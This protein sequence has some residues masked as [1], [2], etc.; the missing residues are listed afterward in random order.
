MFLRS[1]NSGGILKVP[2]GFPQQEPELVRQVVQAAHFDLATVRELVSDRPALAKASWDW[3][4]GDWETG[5]GAASHVGR[6]DIAEYLMAH[7]A[8]PNIFTL[9]M[10]GKLDPVRGMVE[11]IPGIQAAPGP[12]GLTLLHHA[13]AG[14]TEAEAVLAYLQEAGSANLTPMDLPISAGERAGY[15]G[16]YRFGPETASSFK[17]IGRRDQLA[18]QYN[19]HAPRTLLRQAE[20]RFH[21][22]GAPDVLFTFEMDGS[23]AKNLTIVD[24]S[25]TLMA[26]RV[27]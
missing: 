1:G 5:L 4:F 11:A 19:G 27:P 13:R 3:G 20:A 15:L 6:R 10:L 23:F 9:A 16:T 14:G 12:H 21:P 18:F 25:K 22:V 26:V 2:K 7:G 8:R 17:I 24:G